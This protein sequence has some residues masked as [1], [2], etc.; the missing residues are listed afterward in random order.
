MHASDG[1]P[2]RTVAVQHYVQTSTAEARLTAL[3]SRRIVSLW[4]VLAICGIAGVAVL[5]TLAPL[6]AF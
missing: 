5:L 6:L 3:S 1:S 4:V 2:F